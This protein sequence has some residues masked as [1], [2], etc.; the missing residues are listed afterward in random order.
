M[1]GLQNISFSPTSHP[2]FQFS[3]TLVLELTTAPSDIC[4]LDSKTHFKPQLVQI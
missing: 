1:K 2:L 3:V 4:N